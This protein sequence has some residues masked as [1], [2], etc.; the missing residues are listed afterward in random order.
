[1]TIVTT[2][3]SSRRLAALR[4][5]ITRADAVVRRWRARAASVELALALGE[6]DTPELRARHDHAIWQANGYTNWLAQ[7]R[8]TERKFAARVERAA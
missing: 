8:E 7:L 2:T 3:E 1:M 6:E 4:D 5:E